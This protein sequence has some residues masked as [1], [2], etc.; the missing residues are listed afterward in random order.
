MAAVA[1]RVGAR[2]E[3]RRAVVTPGPN[4]RGQPDRPASPCC[5]PGWPQA[6]RWTTRPRRSRQPAPRRRLRRPGRYGARRPAPAPRAAPERD[7]RPVPAAGLEPVC[8]AA[9]TTPPS[10][11]TGCATSSCRCAR[12]RGARP[13]A[14]ARPPG[15][16]LRDEAALMDPWPR[17]RCPTPP[18]P[19]RWRAPPARWPV[20]RCGAGCAAAL[21]RHPP[22]WPRSIACSTRGG[23][24]SGPVVG[25]RRVRR[26]AGR[27]RVEPE[28]STR[29]QPVTDESRG[30]GGARNRRPDLGR[31]EHGPR[32][33]V[34]TDHAE[35][36]RPGLGAEVTKDYAD[37]PP[38]SWQCSGERCS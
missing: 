2:C 17:T 6:T 10:C 8:D 38:C 3:R 25:G 22:P 15:R 21:V 5:R 20:A 19:G 35:R 28:R 9:T 16:V 29:V 7:P 1:Q 31:A 26:T 23:R 32:A 12:G 13:R 24:A 37:E 36:R 18:T 4:L 27:L 33:R 34:G 30:E 11:A 14:A